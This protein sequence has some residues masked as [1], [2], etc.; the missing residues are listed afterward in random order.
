VKNS[1]VET[2]CAI[3]IPLKILNFGKDNKKIFSF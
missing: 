2:L 1:S 3:K